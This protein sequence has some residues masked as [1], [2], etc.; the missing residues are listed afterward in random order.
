MKKI[1]VSASL[2]VG[3]S[4]VNAQI[5][6]IISS[7]D[8]K[9]TFGGGAGIGFSN[10]RGYSG[11][12]I[13]I[14]PRVGY[15]VTEN[16]E[17]GASGGITWLNSTNFNSTMIGLGPFAN[18][19]FGRN[20]YLSARHQHYF[21]NQ[22]DKVYNQKFSTQEDALYIGG[23]YM[24]KIAGGVYMQVGAS[25]NVLYNKNKSVFGTGFVPNVGIVWGL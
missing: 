25:Y 13:S 22:K 8:S 1:I 2:F 24:T 7:P 16:L 4:L 18:Y 3:M 17:V 12:N 9:W 14:S 20:I 19:Y 5:G 11:T 6:G 10:G 23:G 21:I 15:K